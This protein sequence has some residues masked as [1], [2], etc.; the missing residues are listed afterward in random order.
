[1]QFV[2]ELAEYF[3]QRTLDGFLLTLHGLVPRQGGFFE[4]C[5]EGGVGPDGDA[6][7]GRGEGTTVTDGSE[8]NWVLW[9]NR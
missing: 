5:G 9:N 1:M 3:R 2:Q 8:Q 4:L 6:K 7:G